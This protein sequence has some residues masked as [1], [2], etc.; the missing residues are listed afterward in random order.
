[1]NSTTIRPDNSVPD[2]D[3]PMNTLRISPSSKKSS[4]HLNS[5]AGSYY[6]SFPRKNSS[7]LKK[8]CPTLLQAVGSTCIYKNIGHG[9]KRFSHMS[10]SSDEC[11]YDTP[12]GKLSIQVN[13][14]FLKTNQIYGKKNGGT[15]WH[16]IYIKIICE[17]VLQQV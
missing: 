16:G 10:H 11:G 12:D 9:G 17:Y 15:F 7:F 14:K 5:T 1:M 3:V 8:L 13:L 2:S 4:T 6:I